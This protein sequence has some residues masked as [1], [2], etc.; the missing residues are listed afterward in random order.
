MAIPT[1][2]TVCP[3]RAVLERF[4]HGQ[5]LPA[6]VEQWVAHVE[7]C[8]QCCATLGGLAAHDTVADAM[9]SAGQVKEALQNPLVQELIGRLD[10]WR[11]GE[12]EKTVGPACEGA[13]ET[14]DFLAP[15]QS[16]DEQWSTG[17]R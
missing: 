15:A 10:A 3:P 13:A 5:L 4:G 16:A 14:Y 1:K 2:A 17:A 8:G 11:P 12:N 6:E 7:T 9:K